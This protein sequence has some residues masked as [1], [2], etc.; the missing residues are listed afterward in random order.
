MPTILVTGASHGIGLEFVRQY[1]SAGWDVIA[2]ARDPAGARDLDETRRRAGGNVA[3]EPLD[4]TH[5]QQLE[6]LVDKYAATAIDVLVNN[7]G[8]LGPRG[9]RREL[10]HRQFFGSLDYEAWRRVLEVNL[11]APVRIAEAFAPQVERSVEKKMIFVSSA[12]GSIAAGT[13]PVFHYCSSKAALN[14]CVAMIALALQARGVIAVAVCPG[15][16]R[17]ELGG[18]GATLEAADS[19]AALRRLIARLT[20]ADTGRYLQRDGEPV[21]W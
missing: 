5:A 13:V 8:E 17:T 14:K 18:E 2:C 1:A 19:V 10:L 4:V 3:V 15:H 21:P 9:P 6:W 16:V 11:L 20:P 12:L 7:A